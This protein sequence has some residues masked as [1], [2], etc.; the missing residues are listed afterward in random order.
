MFSNQK[1]LHKLLE[2]VKSKKQKYLSLDEQGYKYV[3]LEVFEVD[4]LVKLNLSNNRLVEIST[5]LHKLSNLGKT[6]QSRSKIERLYE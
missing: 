4:G 1:E 5:D 6:I 3:P 2:E